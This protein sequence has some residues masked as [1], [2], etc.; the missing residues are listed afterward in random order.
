MSCIC[1]EKQKDAKKSCVTSCILRERNQNYRI[2]ANMSS[3]EG[4]NN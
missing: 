2:R 1:Q 4:F 3:F